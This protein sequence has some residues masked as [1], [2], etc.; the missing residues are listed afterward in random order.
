MNSCGMWEDFIKQPDK[1]ARAAQTSWRRWF[2]DWFGP[3]NDA[4]VQDQ[5]AWGGNPIGGLIPQECV[6]N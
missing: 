6:L 4:C 1:D 3:I 5:A 2:G